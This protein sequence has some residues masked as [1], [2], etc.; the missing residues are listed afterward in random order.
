M[1]RA[2]PAKVNSELEKA[3][4][5]ELKE[6]RRTEVKDGIKVPAYSLLDRMRVLSVALKLEALKLS[7]DDPSFGTG[8][9]DED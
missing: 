4:E 1:S 6:I 8:F 9:K 2:K 7:A 3:I 5:A